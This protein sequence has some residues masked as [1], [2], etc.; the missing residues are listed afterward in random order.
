MG[1][2]IY[3]SDDKTLLLYRIIWFP[4]KHRKKVITEEIGAG[5]KEICIEIC[6]RYEINFVEIG[7][8]E[9]H[10]HFL[11]ESVPSNSVEKLIR[12]IKS[13]TVKEL[14]KIFPEIKLKLWGC[15]FWT[16]GYY[17]NTVVQYA[18]EKATRKYAENQGKPK[19]NYKKIYSNQL[20]LF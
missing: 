3:K 5:L 20:K 6:E 16:I 8:E 9:E 15:N 13:I 2:H 17:A 11:I 19:E 1:E 7:Y 4:L 14:F 12:T 18:N 10:V